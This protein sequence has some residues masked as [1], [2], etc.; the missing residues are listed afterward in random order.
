MGNQ[1]TNGLMNHL[2]RTF[3]LDA[4]GLPEFA[5]ESKKREY[6]VQCCALWCPSVAGNAYHDFVT[7]GRHTWGSYSSCADQWNALPWMMGCVNRSFLN[8]ADTEAGLTWKAGENISKT[9]R[10]AIALGCWVA[11]K[12]GSGFERLPQPGDM[13]LMGDYNA[14]ELEHVCVVEDIVIEEGT[15]KVQMTSFDYGQFAHGKKCSLRVQREWRGGRLYSPS[16]KSRAIVGWIDV[17]KV[18]LNRDAVDLNSFLP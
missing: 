9:Y 18:P 2:T 8:R 6:A 4:V 12:R 11:Y 16:G 13:L 14:G 3:R 17:C 5:V 7:Q 10:S 1:L 15:G